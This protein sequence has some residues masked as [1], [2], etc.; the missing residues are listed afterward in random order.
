MSFP[1]INYSYANTQSPENG[2]L[3]IKGHWAKSQINEALDKGIV[4]GISA[5]NFA[6]NAPL[7]YEQFMTMLARMF[8]QYDYIKD[9]VSGCNLLLTKYDEEI[10]AS[11]GDLTK[12]KD[13]RENYAN[14]NPVLKDKIVEYS[15][16]HVSS[17]NKKGECHLRSWTDYNYDTYYTWGKP[18]KPYQPES[19]IPIN[20]F[21]NWARPALTSVPYAAGFLA[22][23][24]FVNKESNIKDFD[25]LATTMGIKEEHMT[26]YY[27]NEYF[28]KRINNVFNE[29]NMRYTLPDSNNDG[30]P[31]FKELSREDMALIL[32]SFLNYEEQKLTL[33]NQDF[34]YYGDYDS[35]YNP[36]RNKDIKYKSFKSKFTDIPKYFQVDSMGYSEN[37]PRILNEFY[38]YRPERIKPKAENFLKLYKYDWEE[39]FGLKNKDYEYSTAQSRIELTSRGI[40]LAVSDAG[41]LSGSGNKFYPKKALTRA[42]GVTVVLKL[43]KFIK[44]RYDFE[45][46]NQKT[47]AFK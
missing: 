29:L 13:Y 31:Y 5:N 44:A 11:N 20:I 17:Y 10:A 42:E 12:L 23:Y 7:T 40:I 38:R 2:F 6:P 1:F 25:Y 33:Y 27:T 35:K 39:K 43:E 41:L 28:I 18:S 8:S 9:N 22:Y 26:E 32:Y 14:N 47:G 15:P 37:S 36:W 19:F 4:S 46:V 21:S 24:D 34:Y 16:S 3:D 30:K 45:S